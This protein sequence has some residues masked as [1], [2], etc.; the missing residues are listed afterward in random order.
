MNIQSRPAAANSEPAHP[1]H[2]GERPDD[3]TPN[4][5]SRS[6]EVESMSLP[7]DHLTR[8][9]I[10]TLRRVTSDV[11]AGRRFACFA[12]K[13]AAIIGGILVG[14]VALYGQI[15]SDLHLARLP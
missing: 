5:R 2:R 12:W 10:A 1:R 15:M 4:M 6:P 8:D 13:A 3:D 14:I 7:D 9:E 11:E